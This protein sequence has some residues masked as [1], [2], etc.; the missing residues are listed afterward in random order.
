MIFSNF[1]LIN[2][3]FLLLSNYRNLVYEFISKQK[4]VIPKFHSGMEATSDVF[5]HFF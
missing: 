4:Q 2:F 5:V 3:E 1:G